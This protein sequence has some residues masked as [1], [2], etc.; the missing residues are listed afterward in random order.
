MCGAATIALTLTTIGSAQAAPASAAG[1]TA[2]YIVEMAGA[3]LASYDGGV[4][5]YA[6]TKPA[7][8][9]RLDAHSTRAKAYGD[10]LRAKQT[11]VLRSN[12][13]DTKKAVYQYSTAFNGVA[14]SLTAGQAQKLRT[15]PGVL[16]VFKNST[17][18]IDT[19]VTPS[20]IGLTGKNGVWDK[21]FGGDRDAGDGVIIADIDTGFWPESPSFKPLPEPRRDDA[22]IAAKWHGTCQAGA[23]HP[24]T[25]NSKVI[26]ARYF[27]AA[28][29]SEANPGEFKSPRDFDGHGSHTASTAAGE[30]VNNVVVTGTPVDDVEGVAPGARLAIYKVLYE[31]AD[32]TTASGSSVDIV[33]AV[34]A[35]V[36]DGADVINFSIGDNVDGFGPE[37]LAFLNAA[38]A[39]VFVSAA[40]GNAGPGPSTV[41]NAMPWEA[42]VAAGTHD[43]NY[44]KTVTL[45]NGASYSGV[46]VGAAVPSSPLIDSATAALAGHSASDAT[47]CVVG[48]LDPAKVTG[49]IVLCQRG[50]NARTDKSKAVQQAGGVGMIQW[51]PSPNSLNA[52]FHFVPSIHVDTPA[53]T[54]IK[55]YAATPGATASLSAG[56]KVKV[57]APATASFSSRGPSVSSGGDLLKPDVMAPGNDVVAAVSPLNHNGNLYDTESGTSMAAPHI[58]GIAALILSKHPN[59]S[60]TWVKSAIMT[61][62]T[63]VDNKGKPIQGQNGNGNPLDYGSGEVVP[64]A[65]FNP[66]LVYD[67]TPTQWLQYTCGIGVHLQ[68]SDGSDVCDQT[69]SIAP[70]QLNYPS[71]AFGAL[72]GKGSVSRTVTNVTNRWGLYLADVKAPSGYKVSVNPPLLLI[73][74][75]RSASFTVSVTRTS[76]AL[77]SYSFG[78][79]TWRDLEGHKVYSPIAVQSTA[80]SAPPAISGTGTSGST[81]ISTQAGYTGTLKATAS[82]LVADQV[83]HNALS[84]DPSTPFNPANPAASG[85]TAR[86][87]LT[88]PAGTKLARFS[89]LA[90]DYAA[91]TDIDLYAYSEDASG[92]LVAQVGQSSGS[93]ADETMT[94]TA[95]GRYAVFVDLFASPVTGPVDTQLHSWV[96]TGANAGNFA[97]S[98]ASQSVTLGK[99]AT[100]TASWTGLT[101]GRHYLGLVEYSDGTSG[102]GGTIVSVNP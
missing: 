48:S 96:V 4:Q 25:C 66:G 89:T 52:D 97:V 70:N 74:P 8:G 84:L 56:T 27:D 78:S 38:A 26:G 61:T 14:V 24:V 29:N 64:A 13:V 39:G 23:D 50:V 81:A 58:A 49:H 19:P 57:E 69:G 75:G 34:D 80:L 86:V 40:A 65:T 92:N 77:G 16:A 101:A 47:L 83:A 87:D 35:A 100:V 88:V 28:G 36:S 72:A 6:A 94:F 9:Q 99:A 21:Q 44:T 17:L 30:H 102:L 60:P 10:H 1:P 45:G 15:A 68:L 90:S 59:W 41:D 63:T 55:A 37:E 31:A 85:R 79:L 82:G 20:F 71:I 12:G 91:G 73:G 33:A 76:A 43:V 54:A 3:P 42:T 22:I 7:A 2:L 32:G 95:P 5:G 46:G 98:P 11:D 93:T 62:A 53:G 67:S 18:T 51:N